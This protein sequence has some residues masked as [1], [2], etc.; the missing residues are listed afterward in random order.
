MCGRMPAPMFLCQ[1]APCVFYTVALGPQKGVASIAHF[2]NLLVSAPFVNSLP[3]LGP[4]PQC[5]P[6]VSL[7]LCQLLSLTHISV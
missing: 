6:D 4:L 1:G 2:R 3:F 5:S 7:I